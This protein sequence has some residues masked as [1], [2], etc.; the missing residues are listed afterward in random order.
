M[1]RIAKIAHLTSVHSAFDSRIFQKECRTL[2]TSGYEIV[3]I[4]PHDG[5]GHVDGIGIRA[6]PRARSRRERMLRTVKYVYDRAVA[7][8]ADLYHLHDPELLLVGLALKARGKKVIYDVHENMPLDIIYSKP[9]IHRALRRSLSF[10]AKW[11]ERMAAAAM[12]GV[13]TI[14]ETFASRFPCAKT[15]VVSNYPI[16]DGAVGTSGIPYAKRDALVVFTGGLARGRC[17]SDLVQAIDL[18]PAEM[19]AK[20]VVVG[21]V[22][23]LLQ[24]HLSDMPGWT[25]TEYR[26]VVSREEVMALLAQARVGLLVNVPRRD[27]VDI[28][29]NKLYEYMMMGLPVVA[30]PIPSWRRTVEEVG[31]GIVA[32][33]HNASDLAR[34]VAWLLERPAEAETMGRRGAAA[35]REHFNWGSQA[36]KLLA[37]YEQ[38]LAS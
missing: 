18:I 33:S 17:A 28:S 3:L 32:N 38:L 6:V 15:C 36:E 1:R 11:V 29:T 19:R 7:E 14:T 21:P 20:L 2:A 4:V 34:G 8:N 27:Y 16:L 12:D 24:D 31:C 35:V 25:R 5:D 22:E 9:H 13:V 37:F 10:A 26:G 30:A 23:P